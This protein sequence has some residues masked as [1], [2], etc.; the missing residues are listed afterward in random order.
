MQQKHPLYDMLAPMIEK[1]GFEVVRILTI[2]VK[3]PTLQIMIERKDRQNLVVD[4]CAAVSRA[5]SKVLDE[6]D[7]IDGEYSLEVSSPGLDR[8][9]T[10]PE[11]FRRFAGYEAKIETVAYDENGEAIGRLVISGSEDQS[12]AITNQTSN[13]TALMGLTV[14]EGT[15]YI[16]GAE[17]SITSDTTLGSLMKEIN[18]ASII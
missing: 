15:F 11:H 13:F 5:V 4:D 14:S 16:N 12:I 3:N 18:S 8:P 2:G 7:P 10:K 17:F 1:M 6:K 9:L